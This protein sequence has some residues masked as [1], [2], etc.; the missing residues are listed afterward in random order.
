MHICW[1][2]PPVEE[3]VFKPA[4]DDR[5]IL[6]LHAYDA[7]L[8][9]EQDYVSEP[10]TTWPR[11]MAEVAAEIAADCAVLLKNEGVF[12][13][14]KTGKYLAAG[15]FFTHM[16]YQGSG[17]SMVHPTRLTDPVTAFRSKNI[18]FTQR[19]EEWESC[20][21]ILYFGGLTDNMETE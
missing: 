21:A 5:G 11:S 15:P 6:T 12:P 14:Q 10:D 1:Y 8:K 4:H 7:M 13:L 20:D 2:C 19:E 3:P 9:T 18:A 17:S 16:R